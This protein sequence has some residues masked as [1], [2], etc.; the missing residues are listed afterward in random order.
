MR[1]AKRRVTATA[2][3]VPSEPVQALGL[4]FIPSVHVAAMAVRQRSQEPYIPS[5]GET[6]EH[7]GGTTCLV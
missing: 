3:A 7:R 2:V 6:T 1:S 4:V 5:T